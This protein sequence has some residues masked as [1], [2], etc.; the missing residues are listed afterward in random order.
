MQALKL[1]GCSLF[2]G[3]FLYGSVCAYIKS[4][5]FGLKIQN[6][7]ILMENSRI[8]KNKLQKMFVCVCGMLH[9]RLYLSIPIIFLFRAQ[10]F[11]FSSSI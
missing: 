5:I 3:D 8:S 1:Y 11:F 6:T 9:L 10:S 2:Q 7:N 4:F